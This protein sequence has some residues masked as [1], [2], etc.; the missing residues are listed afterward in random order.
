MTM[1]FQL[2]GFLAI[3]SWWPRS[4]RCESAAACLLGLQVRIPPGEWMSFS[5]ECRVL[6]D[7]DLCYMPIPRPEESYQ[8]CV[9]VCD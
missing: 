4:L 6:S 1:P 7:I 2:R 5:C 8:V 9:C 3:R